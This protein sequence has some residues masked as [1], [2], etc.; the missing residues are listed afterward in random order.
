[1]FEALPVEAA[2]GHHRQQTQEPKRLFNSGQS[3]GPKQ[4]L[5][6]RNEREDFGSIFEL[7]SSNMRVYVCTRFG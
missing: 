3:K 7:C 2:R 1:M 6:I 4:L 5:H